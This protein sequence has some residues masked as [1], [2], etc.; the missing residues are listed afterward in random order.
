MPPHHA[1]STPLALPPLI[2]LLRCACLV[3]FAHIRSPHLTLRTS[4]LPFLH[5]VP[6]SSANLFALPGSALS[7]SLVFDC[8]PRRLCLRSTALPCP[9]RA[10][11]S[12]SHFPS[13][14]RSPLP[15]APLRL[16]SLSFASL[17]FP[18]LG[19][20]SFGFAEPGAERSNNW[21]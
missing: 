19:F 4:V 17:S 13:A 1:R 20:P 10:S 16:A 15:R 7:T 14:S 5:I 18:S 9:P 12:A 2:C 21:L 3:D 11:S 8:P 6:A